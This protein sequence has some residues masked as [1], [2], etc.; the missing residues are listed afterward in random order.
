MFD[1]R[2]L[3]NLYGESNDLSLRSGCAK[4]LFELYFTKSEWQQLEMLGLLDDQSNRLIAR[5]C[6]KS[7]QTTFSF[8]NDEYVFR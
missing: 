6:S 7:E 5:A 2:N 8:L 1:C 4:I 3:K